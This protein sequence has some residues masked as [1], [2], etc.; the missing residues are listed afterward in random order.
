MIKR[1]FANQSTFKTV[2]FSKG[3]NVILADRTK[4]STIKDS[5]NGLGKSTLIE[6]VHFCLGADATK[7][8]GLNVEELS[9]WEFTLELQ[10]GKQ[11]ISVSRSVDNP[12]SVV[13]EADTSSWPFSPKVKKEQKI[14]SI[15]DW[16]SLLGY[17]L[18]G[19]PIEDERDKFQPSYRSVISYF[20]RR[21]KDAFSTP[22][23]HHRKTHEWDK[24]VNNAFLLGL[25]WEDAAVLQV[26]KERKKGLEN[27]RNAAKAGVIQG[28]SGSVGDLEARRVRLKAQ[29]DQDASNLQSFKVH[30]QYEQIEAD[31][32]I[33]TEVIHE[34]INA[35]V[36]DRRML[37]LYEKSL[38]EEQPPVSDAIERLYKEAGVSLPGVTLRRLEDVQSFHK[39]IIE[40]RQSFL[41]AE[42]ERLTR[43]IAEREKLI[44]SKTEE[45]SSLMMVLKTHGALEEYTLLQERYMKTVN[46]LNSIITMIENVNKFEDGLSEIKIES[47]VLQKKARRDYDERHVIRERAISLFNSYSQELYNAPGKLVLDVGSTGFKFDVIIERS[48]SAGISNMKVFCYDLMLARLWAEHSPSPSLLVHDSTI[49]DGV[50]ERQIARAL[51]LAEK[52]AEQNGFQY[53][54]TLNSD[55]VPWNEFPA[56]FD[57]NRYVMLTLTDKSV[58]G[59]L[60]GK[61]F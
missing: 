50:D 51:Q 18:F 59:C 36:L 48:N 45:R 44:G 13:I 1:I 55:S 28:F 2:E 9:G 24:Q 20:I 29:A 57:L 4:D 16:N 60:L 25:A 33:L 26:L 7:N 14:L 52:E 3:F 8:K 39:N 58:D 49:F 56:E 38:S 46:E 11:V 15:R 17:L 21:G 40:N 54:C 6:I 5:R 22:F 34:S 10:I 30:P 37:E 42:I 19:L 53:I 31:A 61:R 27:I 41:A 47:E 43:S 32:N 12:K 35:N 23:E